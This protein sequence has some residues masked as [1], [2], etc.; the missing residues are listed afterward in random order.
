MKK[1]EKILVTLMLSAA[2]S[3][4]AFAAEVPIESA[5]CNATA[6]SIEITEALIADE[7][8][9]VQNGAGYQLAY[10][11]ADNAI[12]NAVIN[13]LTEGYGYGELSSIA[14]NALLQYRDMY[15]RPEYYAEQND[16][17]YR[18][19]EDLIIDVCNGKLYE[20]AVDEAYTRI[21]Q[22]I[23]PYYVPNTGIAVD[24]IYLDMPAA[25]MVMFSRARKFLLE[26]VPQAE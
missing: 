21:Y 6:R 15:L 1:S 11:E 12:R 10:A 3:Q 14:R 18:L 25:D 7:L 2:I 16:R 20:A 23:D 4:T 13:D 9:A 22:S 17:I 26:A 8:T 5:P 24:W 19:I